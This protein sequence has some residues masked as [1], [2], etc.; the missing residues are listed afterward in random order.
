[1][2]K[3]TKI[4]ISEKEYPIR[5]DFMVLRD[6]AEKYKSVHK[7]EMEL[8]GMGK[9]TL[10]G[11]EEVV[12]RIKEPSLSCIIFVLPKMINSALDYQGYEMI[13]EKDIVRDIDINYFE[14]ADIIH[15]EMSKCFK[16][17]VEKKK[18]KYNPIPKKK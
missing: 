14:L 11:G 18:T 13:D 8:L 12:A 9:T 7:F 17:S 15:K 1:M 4:T 3:I 5:F 16:S 10:D 6:V 2:G